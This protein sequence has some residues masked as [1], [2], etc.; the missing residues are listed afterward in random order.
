MSWMQI[1]AIF[2]FLLNGI[3]ILGPCRNNMSYMRMTAGIGLVICTL[4]FFP[5]LTFN[6]L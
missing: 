2:N 3:L 1:W 4:H 5:F 6:L